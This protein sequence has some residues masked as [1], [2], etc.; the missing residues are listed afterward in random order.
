[1][2]PVGVFQ[3]RKGFQKKSPMC[4]VAINCM[5][6]VNFIIFNVSYQF[7]DKPLALRTNHLLLIYL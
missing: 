7:L 5:N 1:M 2:L 6:L 4:A 3:G